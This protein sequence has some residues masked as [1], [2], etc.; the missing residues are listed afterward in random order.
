MNPTA[1][2][3]RHERRRQQQQ[4]L[5]GRARQNVPQG[6]RVLH[7][8]HLAHHTHGRIRDDVKRAIIRP[9]AISKKS[10]EDE[11]SHIDIFFLIYWRKWRKKSNTN[12]KFGLFIGRNRATHMRRCNPSRLC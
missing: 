4:D 10:R 1:G 12:Y 2:R 9:V 6:A 3:E 11:D 7:H 8:G 5:R